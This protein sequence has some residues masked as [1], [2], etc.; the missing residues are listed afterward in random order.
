MK[1]QINIVKLFN[2]TLG[3]LVTDK[4]KVKHQFWVEFEVHKFELIKPSS[5]NPNAPNSN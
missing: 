4:K 3:Y 1:C 2:K 5:S